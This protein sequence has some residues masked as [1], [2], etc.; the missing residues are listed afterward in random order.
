[1][2]TETGSHA[3]LLDGE[4]RD[5]ADGASLVRERSDRLRRW[6]LALVAYLVVQGA[7]LLLVRH[8]APRFFWFDDSQGQF[9]PMA[10]WLGQ[11]QQDGRPPLMNPDLGMGGNVVADPQYGVL[12]PLHWVLQALIGR[13]TDFLAVSWAYGATMLLVL[14]VGS[15][16]LLLQHRV[17]PALAVAGAVGIASSGFLTWYGSSWWPLLWSTACLPWLWLGLRSRGALGVLVTGLASWALLTSGNP[18]AFPFAGL[19]IAGQLVE[20]R[21]EY[22]SWRQVLNV[23]ALSRVVACAGGLVVAIP[24]FLSTLQISSVMGRQGAD[25][26]VG[27]T[28]FAVPN[29][30]DVVL[31]GTT[32]LGETNA[33]TG[34]IGLVP[35]MATMLVALPMAA[36]VDWRRAWQRPGVLTAGLVW[37]AGAVATQLPTT[38]LVFR[39]PVRYLVYVEFA[40]PLLVLIAVT[41][42]P[43]LTRGRLVGA[44]ALACTQALFAEFRAPVFVKWHLL[45]LV[46]ELLALAAAVLLLRARAAAADADPVRTG[47]SPDDTAAIPL[48]GRGHRTAAGPARTRRGRAPAA[49]GAVALVLLVSAGF[50]I[51]EQMMVSLQE[52]DNVIKPGGFPTGDSPLRAL[53]PGRELGTTVADYRAESYA[54]DQE[55]TVITWQFDSDRGWADGVVNGSGNVIAGLEPGF[56]SLAVWQAALN[57]RWCRGVWGATCSG[58]DT[59]L[60]PAGDT[61]LPWVDLMSAD[62]VLLST[63][64]PQEVKDHFAR[65][66]TEVSA[67]DTWLRYQR[68]DGLPGRITAATGVTTSPE[69]WTSGLARV[70]TPMDSYVV[71]TGDTDGTLAMRI[72]Y[73]PGLRA[74]LDGADLPVTTVDGAA[75]AVRVPAG[76]S[77]GRL[78]VFYEPTGASLVVPATAAGVLLIVLASGAALVARRRRVA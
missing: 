74:T 16:F 35:A 42:A 3:A 7:Q 52:R 43:R 20:Y 9:G 29:L 77:S 23:R 58:P 10:W 30:G 72:P 39:Y 40:L 33:W 32:L 54:P 17:Q 24:G 15:L 64:A 51:G 8:L 26:L 78:D 37:L 22:G 55:M 38:V 66:W 46:L 62:T 41:A 11:N 21:R 48:P 68:D 60:A 71:S 12:D 56:A 69:G 49:V 27:N 47:R 59:L 36:L 13:S 25:P 45:V 6:G 50:P 70:G 73:Y 2:T 14:G 61:G 1:M 44:A 28:G 4:P 75:L 18:Y 57:E 34:G 19:I 65:S 76:V 63:G 53:D 5:G 31:G 67:D